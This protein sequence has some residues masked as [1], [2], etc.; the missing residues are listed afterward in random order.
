[1]CLLYSASFLL[2][3]NALHRNHIIAEKA[4]ATLQSRQIQGYP[5]GTNLSLSPVPHTNPPTVLIGP[6][7]AP[8][9]VKQLPPGFIDSQLFDL[10]RP[11]GPLYSARIQ[12]PT[13]VYNASDDS[14]T[15]IV[16]FYR[17]EDA[18]KA[19]EELHCAEVGDRNIAVTVYHQPRRS[20][21]TSEISATAP[22]FI[23]SGY[24]VGINP[25]AQVC[26]PMLH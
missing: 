19:E 6:S 11:Y 15:G 20:N 9:L 12:H 13:G 25:Y 5:L 3:D 7:A 26:L 8:R 22:P 24:G 17:E 10:F 4:L 16:E 2:S 21:T 14:G 18:K 23:P 1:M